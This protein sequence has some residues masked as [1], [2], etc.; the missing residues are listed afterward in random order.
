MIG[1][2]LIIASLERKVNR[3][4]TLLLKPKPNTPIHFNLSKAQC[5]GTFTDVIYKF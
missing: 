4:S 3:L 2:R 5:N 1:Q